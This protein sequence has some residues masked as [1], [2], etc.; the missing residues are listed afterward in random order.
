M[1]EKGVQC[2]RCWRVEHYKWKCSNIKIE[3]KKRRSEK[4]AY[5]VSLQKM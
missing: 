1:V 5:A 4:V 2:F 3:K